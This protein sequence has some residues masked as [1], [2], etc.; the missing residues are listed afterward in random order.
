[1]PKKTK[2]IVR[3]RSGGKQ[4]NKQ[5]NKP[6]MDPHTHTHTSLGTPSSTFPPK[7]FP[8]F[9]LPHS[10][11]PSQHSSLEPF[12]RNWAFKTLLKFKSP[13]GFCWTPTEICL[14]LSQLQCCDRASKWSCSKGTLRGQRAWGSHPLAATYRGNRLGQ[15]IQ[16]LRTRIQA[17]SFWNPSSVFLLFEKSAHFLFRLSQTL[18]CF[19]RCLENY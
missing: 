2:V 7:Y 1:M 5:T 16:S 3:E 19:P 17:Y 6:R 14:F 15:G 11:P 18:P 4:T 10:P 9:P 13:V 8:W 12:F